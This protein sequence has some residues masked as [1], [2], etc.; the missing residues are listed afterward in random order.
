MDACMININAIAR[1]LELEKTLPTT[2]KHYSLIWE[3]IYASETMPVVLRNVRTREPNEAGIEDLE[4]IIHL[5]NQEAVNSMQN[6]DDGQFFGNNFNT[7]QNFLGSMSMTATL[8]PC[9]SRTPIR[10]P[11]HTLPGF[12]MWSSAPRSR[13]SWWYWASS[14]WSLSPSQQLQLSSRRFERCLAHLSCIFTA[15]YLYK[16]VKLQYKCTGRAPGD[17]GEFIKT[18]VID[19]W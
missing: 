12:A 6:Q 15:A 9:K 8:H 1:I 7:W 13:N 4:Q 11:K 5:L 18:R 16:V 17:K 19:N 3:S 10:L 2:K 14:I